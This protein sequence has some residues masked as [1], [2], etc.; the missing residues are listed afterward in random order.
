MFKA[1]LFGLALVSSLL[2]TGCGGGGSGGGG[3]NTVVTPYHD[4]SLGANPSATDA[5]PAST[6]ITTAS[7][8]DYSWAILNS[9]TDGTTYSN[10][11]WQIVRDG[12]VWKSGTV[13]SI[14]YLG[15]A[16]MSF[17]GSDT[18][19]SHTYTFTIDPNNL[20]DESTKTNNSFTVTIMVAVAAP[21]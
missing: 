20:Q 11:Q 9:S 18:A 12:S 13:T 10:V 2:L 1:P 5:N 6:Q 21:A 19:G 4:L 7:T 8:I 16:N 17:T 3:G 14:P 15:S